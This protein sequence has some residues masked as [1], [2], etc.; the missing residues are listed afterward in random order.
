MRGIDGR[1][2][3][4]APDRDEA[5]PDAQR[6]ARTEPGRTRAVRRPGHH[7]RMAARVFVPVEPGRWKLRPPERGPVGKRGGLHL[8]EH[9]VG[10]A[11]VGEPHLPAQLRPGSSRWPGFIRKKVTVQVACTHRAGGRARRAVEPARHV[12]RHNRLARSIDGGH[13]LGRG[14]VERPR[15]PGA[16]QGIDDDLGARERRGAERLRLA[17]ARRHFRRIALQRVT[18][19]EQTEPHLVAALA[20]QA[21]RHE[22]VAA[23]VPGPARH[24]DGRAGTRSK[25]RRR[26]GH[27][28]PGILH[29]DEPRH[30]A[31]RRQ[32]IG[33]AHLGCGQQFVARHIVSP[34]AAGPSSRG[35]MRRWLRGANPS[36]IHARPAHSTTSLAE[37]KICANAEFAGR[38]GATRARGCPVDTQ[39]SFVAPRF[40][41]A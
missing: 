23:I 15:Q 31:L 9:G 22:P 39:N 33:A 28:T 35:I 3:R 18:A 24:G 5:G 40:V 12:D 17:P 20:Q 7:H 30:A 1:R 10:N 6:A 14:A 13:H 2:R 38:F 29:Q 32:T 25:R 11:D 34:T 36:K 26:I 41:A 21:R 27:G 19:A 4:G 37:M 16:E 8:V